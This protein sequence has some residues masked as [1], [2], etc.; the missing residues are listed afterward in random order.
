MANEQPSI[1]AKYSLEEQL[2]FKNRRES[3]QRH[4]LG[5]ACIGASVVVGLVGT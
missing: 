4:V 3:I 2:W 5:G 1:F